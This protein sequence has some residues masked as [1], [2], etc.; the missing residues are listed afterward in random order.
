MGSIPNV[1]LISS[2]LDKVR[3]AGQADLS[4]DGDH[5]THAKFRAAINELTLAVET[6][7]ET[8]QRIIYQVSL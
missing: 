6:S 8:V 3:L 7:V 4:T 5:Q 1:S 2:L